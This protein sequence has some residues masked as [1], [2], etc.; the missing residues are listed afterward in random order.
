MRANKT[1]FMSELLYSPSGGVTLKANGRTSPSVVPTASVSRTST[2]TLP[3]SDV[4]RFHWDGQQTFENPRWSPHA[5]RSGNNQPRL[6]EEA[7][8]FVD[9]PAGRFPWLTSHLQAQTMPE[10]SPLRHRERSFTHGMTKKG[11][12]AH[13]GIGDRPAVIRSLTH[14]HSLVDSVPLDPWAR[15]ER[16]ASRGESMLD[17]I[18]GSKSE[19]SVRLVMNHARFKS[20]VRHVGFS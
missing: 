12:P 18:G 11:T 14:R 8:R 7:A 15:V 17:L 16:P 13:V 9:F 6:G 4:R 3:W 19:L 2:R 1:V 10:G 5:R 20:S